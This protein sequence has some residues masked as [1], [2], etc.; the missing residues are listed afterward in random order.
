MTLRSVAK[1][2]L[3]TGFCAALALPA[4]ARPLTEEEDPATV[5]HRVGHCD[6][7]RITAISGRIAPS[8]Y[9]SGGWTVAFADGLHVVSG[10]AVPG[11]VR[12][13]RVGDPARVCLVSIPHPCPA[14]DERGRL[15]RV[16]DMRVHRTYL[17]P[18]AWHGCGGA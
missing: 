18:N 2:M 15:F 1:A 16:T 3:V 8:R 13:A 10:L 4:G 12:L 11:G 6:L 9:D 5:P 14:H 17:A 7:T